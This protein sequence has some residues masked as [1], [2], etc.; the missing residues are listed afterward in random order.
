MNPSGLPYWVWFLIGW[1][2]G[3]A[4]C[5]GVEMSDSKYIKMRKLG[6]LLIPVGS[7]GAI[8]CLFIGFIRFVKLVW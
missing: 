4:A 3:I 7:I 5:I 1:A 6:A 2:C 8:I